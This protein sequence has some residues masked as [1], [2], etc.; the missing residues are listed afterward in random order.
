MT[1]AALVAHGVG[2]GPAQIADRFVARVG[3]VH[4]RELAGPVAARQLD[5]IA[6][7][8]L[9]PLPGLARDERRGHHL[10]VDPELLQAPV[11][12]KTARARFIDAVEFHSRLFELAQGALQ[13]HERAAHAPLLAHFAPAPAL[14]QRDRDTFFVDVESNITMLF[15]VLVSW[16]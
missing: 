9:D 2:P 7:V 8:R 10:A 16:S 12:N 14:G 3:H 4:R 5:R 1:A 6:P 15:H 13:R 11:D